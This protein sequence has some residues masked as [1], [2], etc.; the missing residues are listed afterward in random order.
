MENKLTLGEKIR[1]FRKRAGLSQFELENKIGASAGTLSRIESNEVNPTKE[2]LIRLAD[3]LEL[4]Q[5]DAAELF[6]IDLK[7]ELT[8][9]GN[10]S[11]VLNTSIDM[12]E[13]FTIAVRNFIDVIDISFAS[14]WYWDPEEGK[15]TLKG[16]RIPN[17]VW[18]LAAK[19]LGENLSM[20]YF[21]TSIPSHKN[22][23]I[24]QTILSGKV[25]TVDDF[26]E[27]ANPIVNKITAKLF[28]KYLNA[29]KII[30]IPI[31]FNEIKLGVIGLIYEK[32]VVTEGDYLRFQAFVDQI[33]VALYNAKRYSELR[34]KYSELLNEKKVL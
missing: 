12:D 3:S 34:E 8:K 31:I 27:I 25:T 1:S 28:Q 4:N 5:Y 24:L 17:L 32:D 9:I 15:L 23:G 10:V 22:N 29:K 19:I 26:Y 33:A 6:N 20:V 18:K 7:G 21:S 13:I 11:K 14:I 16:V 30:H 2:T